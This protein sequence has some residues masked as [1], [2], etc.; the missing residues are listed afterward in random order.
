MPPDLSQLRTDR[1]VLTRIVADDLADLCHMHRDVDVMATLGGVRSD[2]LSA[3]ILVQ[4]MTHWEQHGF[5]YWMAHDAD[6]GAFVGRG[7]LREVVVGGGPEIEV[8]YALMREYWG[9]GLATELARACVRVGFDALGR[10]DLVAFTL[11]TNDASRRVMQRVGFLY[12][13]DVIWAGMPHVL[14]RLPV[15]AWREEQD[16][17]PTTKDQRETP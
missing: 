6:S 14:Y 16:S 17:G 1:L 8:G 4:L 15:E 13:R 10:Q 7:G 11:P 12:E 9:R 3:E 5:G 2:E